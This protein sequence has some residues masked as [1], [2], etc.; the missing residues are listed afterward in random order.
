MEI[1]L[2]KIM[3]GYGRDYGRNL[4]LHIRIMELWTFRVGKDFLVW[5]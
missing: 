4:L 5:I 2:P 1:D 3:D